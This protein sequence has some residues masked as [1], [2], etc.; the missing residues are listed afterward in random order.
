MENAIESGVLLETEIGTVMYERQADGRRRIYMLKDDA[1]C[2]RIEQAET[3]A[4]GYTRFSSSQQNESSTEVQLEVI[5]RHCQE[6]G[7]AIAEV[8]GDEGRTGTNDR[9]PEFQLAISAIR[10]RK[11]PG[12][13]KGRK[14]AYVVVYKFD[15]FSRGAYDADYYKYILQKCGVRVLSATEQI[16]EGAIGTLVEKNLDAAAAF[17]SAQLSDRTTEYM[18]K[19]A[20]ECKTNGVYFPGYKRGVDGTFVFDIP[21][22]REMRRML[23]R[24]HDGKTPDEVESL[25]VGIV[26]KRGRKFNADRIARLAQD[27]RFIGEYRYSDVTIPDGMP[28]LIDEKSFAEI[29]KKIEAW[30][31]AKRIRHRKPSKLKPAPPSK[32]KLRAMRYK[33]NIKGRR[34]GL[35]KTIEVVRVDKNHHR[36]WLCECKCGNKVEVYATRLK[37]GLA[38]DCGCVSGGGRKRDEHGRFA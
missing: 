20:K 27:R 6:A 10:A 18:H 8:Y 24:L 34:F 1:Y 19:H 30:R 29:G 31:S 17:F 32:K 9:R 5:F 15:R 26:D 14:A 36:I 25:M 12:V 13:P 11:V 37:S 2:K 28:A 3:I 23:D 4:I 38:T 22:S 16:P 33:H 35:L 7:T 21:F